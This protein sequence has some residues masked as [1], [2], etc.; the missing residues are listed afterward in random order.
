MWA[1]IRDIIIIALAVNGLIQFLVWI[2]TVVP[3]SIVI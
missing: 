1:N 3:W 2:N